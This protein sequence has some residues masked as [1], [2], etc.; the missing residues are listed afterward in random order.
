MEGFGESKM[1]NVLFQKFY[2]FEELKQAIDE[3]ID[4]YNT[5]RLQKKLKG[6]TPIEYRNQTLAH[7]FLFF[8]LSTWQGAVHLYFIRKSL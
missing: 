4:F 1:W 7:N 2:T 5:K 8:N 3:Y 6:L